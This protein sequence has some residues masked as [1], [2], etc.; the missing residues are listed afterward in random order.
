MLWICNII[1]VF[2]SLDRLP[3]MI[4]RLYQREHIL[5]QL[6]LEIGQRPRSLAFIIGSLD[7]TKTFEFVLLLLP[8]RA[9]G[10]SVSCT[11]E[12]VGTNKDRWLIVGK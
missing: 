6:L 12:L 10:T 2:G 9:Y 11:Y 1:N 7:Y 5:W 3:L 4:M 8:K